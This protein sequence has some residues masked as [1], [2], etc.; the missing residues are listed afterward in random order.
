MQADLYIES[1]L[2][3]CNALKHSGIW[4]P[5]P[6]VRPEAWLHNF[7]DSKDRLI[8]A[9][10]LDNFIFYSD[11]TVGRLLASCY[12]RLEDDLILGRI[13]DPAGSPIAIDALRFT[14]IEGENPRPTDSG[15][16]MCKRL[17]DLF[18]L[19]DSRFLAP[20]LAV[21]AALAGAPIVF[22]DDVL[23]S[24]QQLM[25]S[26]R[27]AY[28]SQSPSSFEEAFNVRPFSALCIAL[29]ATETAVTN[30]ASQG[31]PISIVATH[32]LDSSYSVENLEA[33]MLNPPIPD[34]RIALDAFLARY[35]SMLTLPSFLRFGRQPLYGF[36]ELGLLFAVQGGVPDSTLPVCWAPAVSDAWVRL[37][38]KNV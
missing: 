31:S 9:V 15:N 32:F 34:F 28:R 23:G 12:S 7:K 30:V 1:V 10:L 19:P 36:H 27:R 16:T 13:R 21:E 4:A 5:E 33:P 38:R 29:V 20:A 26:W 17:R 2:A 6:H 24:G 3:K 14:P 8:A 35:V 37:V 18:E 11:R 25:N 22:V